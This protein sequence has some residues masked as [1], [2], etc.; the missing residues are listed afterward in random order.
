MRVAPAAPRDGRRAARRYACAPLL[1]AASLP[2]L[3]HDWRLSTAHL[4]RRQITS[5]LWALI[6]FA[7]LCIAAVLLALLPGPLTALSAVY[8]TNF[9][10]RSI[11]FDYAVVALTAAVYVRQEGGALALSA[12]TAIAPFAGLPLHFAHA[13]PRAK[14]AALRE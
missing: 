1:R 5:A 4:L 3:T 10:A 8:K 9:L 7:N 13:A 12:F 14:P 6:G 11:L 2:L